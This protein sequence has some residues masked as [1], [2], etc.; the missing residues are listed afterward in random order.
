MNNSGPRCCVIALRLVLQLERVPCLPQ[1][2]GA[3][4]RRL[5]PKEIKSADG[6]V[7][8]SSLMR[9][10]LSSNDSDLMRGSRHSIHREPWDRRLFLDTARSDD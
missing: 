6:Q 10:L 7:R 5:R 8:L 4:S 1:W 9:D 3:A 2:R